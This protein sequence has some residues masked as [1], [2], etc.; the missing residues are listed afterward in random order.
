MAI[1]LGTVDLKFWRLRE[2]LTIHEISCLVCDGD[3]KPDFQYDLDDMPLIDT[4][5][6]D[7]LEGD[8]VFMS[9]L[10]A[11]VREDVRKI[12]QY[13]ST[14]P[15]LDG[16]GFLSEQECSKVKVIFSSAHPVDSISESISIDG[17][18]LLK[19]EEIKR[20]LNAKE[21]KPSFFYPDENTKESG[22]IKNQEYQT[23]LMSI[24]YDTVDRYYGENYDPNDR[25]TVP[26]QVNVIEWLEYT[27]AL[28]NAEARAIDKLTRPEQGKPPQGN[29]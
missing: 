6:P 27:Y 3:P 18:T 5:L 20:W 1:D 24:M 12:E 9:V 10:I 7:Y 26:K 23:R 2:R 25:D 8:D 28:S 19:T 11:A 21:L 22:S 4:Y 13:L 16:G 29:N 15:K 14:I 17:S